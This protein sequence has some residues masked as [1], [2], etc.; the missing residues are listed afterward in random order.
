MRSLRSRP[1]WG[2]ATY[3]PAMIFLYSMEVLVCSNGKKPATRFHARVGRSSGQ[4]W[5][6]H[7]GTTAVMPAQAAPPAPPAPRLTEQR[8]R[9]P[10]RRV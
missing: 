9:R 2:G 4:P 1:R 7:D 3:E 5:E 8:R 6:Q 10:L